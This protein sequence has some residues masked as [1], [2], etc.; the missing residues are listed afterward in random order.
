MQKHEGYR[1]L[2][3]LPARN[4]ISNIADGLGLIVN[5]YEPVVTCNFK[6][7][8]LAAL[9]RDIL[10]RTSPD[11]KQL[12]EKPPVPTKVSDQGTED[13]AQDGLEG[14][15]LMFRSG[16]LPAQ[17]FFPGLLKSEVFV[18]VKYLNSLNAP[19]FLSGADGAARLAIFTSPER[20]K[21]L[22]QKHP[23]YRYAVKA[24]CHQ[25]LAGLPAGNGLVM[26]PGSEAVTFQMA[27]D[28]FARFKA[29]FMH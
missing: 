20:A 10:K 18:P 12:S 25:V 27:P 6:P 4:L 7:A 5:P 21:S 8:Q 15:I 16:V 29:D 24:P 17:Q 13:T 26:N 9:K 28:Q 3:T 19:L 11:S 23:Q 1:C 14:T 22:Q 2:I